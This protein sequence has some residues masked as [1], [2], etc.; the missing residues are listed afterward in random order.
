MRFLPPLT[1]PRITAAAVGIAVVAL[2]AWLWGPQVAHGVVRTGVAG[3]FVLI[4]LAVLAAL[5][6]VGLRVGPSLRAVLAAALVLVFAGS[7]VAWV[8][9]A[10]DV[11]RLY[12]ADVRTVDHPAPSFAERSPY[13]VAATSS[14][15]NLG[16]TTGTALPVKSLTD[17]RS[18]GLWDALVQRRGFLAGYES[19]QVQDMPLFGQ[20]EP[21]Q[22]RT[23]DFTRTARLRVG[24]SLPANSLTR[25]IDAATPP[26]VGF[27]P[28]DVYGYCDGR[29]PDVVVPLTQVHGFWDTSYDFF[30][31]AL[32][33]GRTGEVR[34]VTRAADLPGPAYPQS[35]AK[36]QR[37]ALR[38]LGSF[39]DYWFHRSGYEDTSD[40]S[41]N[42]DS[43]NP[44]E[45]GLRRASDDHATYVTPLTP[46]GSSSSVVALSVVDASVGHAGSRNPITVYE[47][48]K[49]SARQAN[50]SVASTIKTTYSYLP[51]WASGLKIFEIVPGARN[52]W[53]ASIG[54]SQGVV[55]RA[56]IDAAGAA[57]LYDANG[58]VVTRSGTESAGTDGGTGASGSSGASGSAG[59]PDL[60]KLTP[61]QL[62][63][64]AQAALNELAKRAESSAPPTTAPSPTPGG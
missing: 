48:E 38:A 61:Q 8:R 13:D 39:G 23:C 22:V 49:G 7:V 35:L 58:D 26:T 12:V 57:T 25:A 59:S 18:H 28:T 21:D 9:H 44:S 53:V 6:L 31:D 41:D 16:D 33:N 56:V 14:T 5:V 1:G 42:P 4:P 20:T 19:V 27:E 40:D 50:S 54:Q 29:A 60:S 47:Y 52:Q 51:D 55:Y 10:Y 45:L 64:L 34:I 17:Q 43:F 11:D 62:R 36:R 15:K 32:Y 3:A 46:P 24:G 2:I 30:G 37:T 63:D